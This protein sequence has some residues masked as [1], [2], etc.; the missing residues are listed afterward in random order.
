MAGKGG[1]AWKVA[2]ADFVTAMMAFFMVMWLTSQKP[3][4]KEALGSYF[5]DPWAKSR[6][7]SNN[8]RNPTLDKTKAG[9]TNPGKKFLGSNP[10]LEPHDEPESLE[11]KKPKITT[12]RATDRTATGTV[13]T[14][15]EGTENLDEVGKKKLRDLLPRLTG[16]SYKI[17]IRG[18]ASQREQHLAGDTE[19]DWKRCYDRSLAVMRHLQEL[20]IEP[21]R[22]RLCQA[23]GFEPLTIGVQ[24]GETDKNVRVEVFMLMETVESLQ[25]TESQRSDRVIKEDS[26]PEGSEPEEHPE[27]E[28]NAHESPS[29]A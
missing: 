13:I 26:Q 5:R 19:G 28:T 22:L 16:L 12:V 29:H 3:A 6:L 7:N 15:A 23:S 24:T 18:H 11:S 4:T 27:S 10:M 2:Y 20:G 17:E 25:G 9:E 1:G 21:E 14:F 8:V